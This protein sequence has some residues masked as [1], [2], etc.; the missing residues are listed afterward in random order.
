MLESLSNSTGAKRLDD[1]E[2]VATV[3][4][5]AEWTLRIKSFKDVD[6]RISSNAVVSQLKDTTRDS[7]GE[8]AQGRYLRLICKGRLLQPDHAPIQ[9]FSVK[10]G[11]V[12]HAVLA[13]AQTTSNN[14]SSDTNRRRRRRSIVVGPGGRVT[15]AANR[16]NGDSS[17]DEEEGRERIGF[18]RL[19]SSGLSRQEITA[20]RAYFSRHVDR[21][22]QQHSD[23]HGEETDLSRRRL[24][25]EDDWMA[26]QGPVSGKYE[27][28]HYLS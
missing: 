26:M 17:S 3:G 19:R 7:L 6:I 18:D 25:I 28:I 4:T 22:A 10:D 8:R 11:D 14:S 16:G 23:N 1:E 9:E 13:L 5:L 15:R 24:L 21:Y 27:M 2:V 12:V 20:I